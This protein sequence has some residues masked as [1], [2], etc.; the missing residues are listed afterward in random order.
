MGLLSR[1]ISDYCH[2]AWVTKINR[3]IYLVNLKKNQRLLKYL[4][5]TLGMFAIGHHAVDRRFNWI[6]MGYME[7]VMQPQDFSSKALELTRNDKHQYLL[8][9]S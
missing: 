2:F 1:Q 9:H 8:Q 7:G 6:T 5:A 4:G 3:F